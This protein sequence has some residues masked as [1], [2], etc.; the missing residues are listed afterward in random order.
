MTLQVLALVG[1]SQS[2]LISC[3]VFVRGETW[4]GVT[5][6]L[7]LMNL[8]SLVTVNATSQFYLGQH[9]SVTKVLQ[10][11][12]SVPPRQQGCS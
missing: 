12:L 11:F 3:V 10:S 9:L 4:W 7:S 1:S 8:K 5:L 2:P 6:N